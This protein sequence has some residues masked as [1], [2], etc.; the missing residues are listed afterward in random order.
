M[1][2]E[3]VQHNGLD[4]PQYANE[5]DRAE[6]LPLPLL[7]HQDPQQHHRCQDPGPSCDHNEKQG[8]R[9]QPY[10]SSWMLGP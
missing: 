9:N 8:Q 7:I 4:S 5:C 1:D 10:R 6:L 3:K 2:L